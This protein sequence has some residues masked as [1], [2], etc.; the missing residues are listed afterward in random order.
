MIKLAFNGV[1]Q[2]FRMYRPL[3]MTTKRF[4]QMTESDYASMQR[5]VCT[6]R[7]EPLATPLT[8]WNSHADDDDKYEFS[9]TSCRQCT[10]ARESPD[11]ARQEARPWLQTDM[12]G[13]WQPPPLPQPILTR[14]IYGSRRERGTML[15]NVRGFNLAEI[16]LTTAQVTISKFLQ[17]NF[18]YS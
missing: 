6:R 16:E 5:H 10:G 1:W 18:K 4:H 15:R 12:R 14:A 8:T 9:A 7:T 17:Q 2:V 13:M 11:L 3:Q